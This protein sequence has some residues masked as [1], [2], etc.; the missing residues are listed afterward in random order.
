MCSYHPLFL[1]SFPLPLDHGPFLASWPLQTL[2]IKYTNVSCALAS[3]ET[4]CPLLLEW[5]QHLP[6]ELAAAADWPLL[7][8]NHV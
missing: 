6:Q 8:S 1:N 2:Q 7:H 4:G 5:L 3:V